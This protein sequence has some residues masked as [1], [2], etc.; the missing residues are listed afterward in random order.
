M[1]FLFNAFVKCCYESDLLIEMP[2]ESNL[3]LLRNLFLGMAVVF[4]NS[5]Q[6]VPAM[7]ERD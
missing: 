3:D 1:P 5:A 2:A 4:V 6:F 7:R